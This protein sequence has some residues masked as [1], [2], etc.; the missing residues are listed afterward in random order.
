MYACLIDRAC[1]YIVS[2]KIWNLSAFVL[3]IHRV[4]RPGGLLIWADF[5][6]TTRDASVADHNAAEKSP[7]IVRATQLVE[8]ACARQGAPINA[9]RDAPLLLDPQNEI[10]RN[11]ERASNRA[12]GFTSIRSAAKM[13]PVTPWHPSPHMRDAG[14]LVRQ[15]AREMW[16]SFIPMFMNEGLS[17]SEAEE[18]AAKTYMETAELGT[19]QLY[20]NYHV[21]Y[22]FKPV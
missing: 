2:G 16:A 17:E 7:H 22:A 12:K 1:S 3:E 4:L 21:L 18:L 11:E 13:L 8:A 10:W 5:E 6:T 20:V 9:W 14:T 19:K 15:S